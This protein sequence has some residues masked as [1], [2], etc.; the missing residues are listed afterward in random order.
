MISR[1]EVAL[2]IA[3]LGLRE[4][5]IDQRAFSTAVVMT[6]ITTIVTPVLLKAMLAW[7]Q[8]PRSSPLVSG[9][10]PLREPLECLEHERPVGA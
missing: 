5:V 10:A 9:T 3:A 7:R 8:A 6:L 1:G 4:G 2:A